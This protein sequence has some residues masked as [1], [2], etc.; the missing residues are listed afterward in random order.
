MGKKKSFLQA[1]LLNKCP[2][3]REGNIFTCK[4][5]Y[6][7]SKTLSMHSHCPIC[8]QATE[9]ELGFYYGTGYV[10]Y[11]ITIAFSVATLIAWWIFI[12]FSSNDNR[13]I[14]WIVI[15]GILL[16]L[17]QPIFMRLSRSIW[18]SWFFKRGQEE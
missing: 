4:N 6:R 9:L 14:W 11:A 15:N 13:I 5:P 10:S 17:L 7:L 3:C 8:N 2:R 12:G 1:V 18:L 16:I